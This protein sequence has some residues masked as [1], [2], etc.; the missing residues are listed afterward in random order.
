MPIIVIDTNVLRRALEHE[1]ALKENE[2]TKIAYEVLSRL[3]NKEEGIFVVN[4]K[5]RQEYYRH[6]EE[7]KRQLKQ[8]RLYPQ[9]FPL[10][11][12]LKLKLRIVEDVEYNFEI[13][14]E[15]VG[16]KDYHL[17]NSAKSGALKFEEQVAFVLTFAQD[18]YRGKKS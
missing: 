9:S 11:R 18:V 16:R 2:E 7:L 12:S 17:L 8:I 14:G 10:L 6:L 3:L 1:K 15:Q 4:T 5:T 13:F